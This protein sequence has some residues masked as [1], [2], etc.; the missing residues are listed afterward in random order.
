LTQ[1]V[2]ECYALVERGGQLFYMKY[3]YAIVIVITL[4]TVSLTGYF[5][6]KTEASAGARATETLAGLEVSRIEELNASISQLRADMLALREQANQQA[7][8]IARFRINSDRMEDIRAALKGLE[9]FSGRATASE[10]VPDAFGAS[11]AGQPANA[12]APV[13]NSALALF[14]NQEF[15]ILFAARVEDIINLVEHK[16]LEEEFRKKVEEQHQRNNQRIEDFAKKQS[17]NDYQKTELIRIV[18]DRLEQIRGLSAPVLYGTES[19]T[20]LTP[21]QLSEREAAIISDNNEKIKSILSIQ[22]YEQYKKDAF[23]LTGTGR[24]TSRAR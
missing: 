13:T 20:A 8:E 10:P 12:E 14:R 16:K 22:Q 2:P 15:A 6:F 18:A 3:L 11:T 19:G 17:L 21:E 1:A 5:Y 23:Y 4:V 9:S 24:A 7:L